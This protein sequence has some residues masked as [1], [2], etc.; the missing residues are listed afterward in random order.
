MATRLRGP[1]TEHALLA[2]LAMLYGVALTLA[3]AGP[4]AQSH[5]VVVRACFAVLAVLA[6]ITAEAVWLA[7]PWASRAAGLLG[8]CTIRACALWGPVTALLGYSSDAPGWFADFIA[9]T[10][11][12]FVAAGILSSVIKPMVRYVERTLPGAQP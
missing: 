6:W 9:A 5:G 10:I 7:R 4:Y 3:V 2:T 12:S 11:V 1:T 8:R